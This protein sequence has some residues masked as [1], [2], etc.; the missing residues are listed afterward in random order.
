MAG[1]DLAAQDVIIAFGSFDCHHLVASQRPPAGK[2]R[3]DVSQS[4]SAS[5]RRWPACMTR[6]GRAGHRREALW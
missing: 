2:R 5:S 3:D 6:P 4:A 1:P